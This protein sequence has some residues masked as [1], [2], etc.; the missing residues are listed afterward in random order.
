MKLYLHL[1]AHKTGTTVLQK[2]L[3]FNKPLM[4][5]NGVFYTHTLPK[6]RFTK[7]TRY[8]VA[9]QRLLRARARDDS[10][11][12]TF[13]TYWS[14]VREAAERAECSTI[15]TSREGYLGFPLARYP[16]RSS[17]IN[18]LYAT[19]ELPLEL[20]ADTSGVD[21]I[22]PILYIRDQASW[23]ES[24]YRETVVQGS[25]MSIDTLLQQTDLPGLSWV[26][27]IERIE[28]LFGTVIVRPYELP[29]V[30]VTA[31]N[32]HF[33]SLVNPALAGKLDIPKLNPKETNRS[34]SE[35]GVALARRINGELQ[36]D[37]RETIVRMVQEE[38]PSDQFPKGDLLPAKAARTLQQLFGNE[39]NTLAPSVAE[40]VSN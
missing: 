8:H 11:V 35:A 36:G 3:R 34:L 16:N 24:V 12:A 37:K 32:E 6:D 17:R 33:I 7:E 18:R 22:V 40:S 26:P 30:G 28:R 13:E 19:A 15:L 4:R 2:T 21:E 14:M 25:T 10:V 23:L 20:I 27:L 31:H 5:R 38:M 1:G 29:R 39:V 9:I